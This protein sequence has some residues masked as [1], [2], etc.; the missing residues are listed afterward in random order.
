MN[1]YRTPAPRTKSPEDTP[2]LRRRL[3]CFLGAH[4]Y[5]SVWFVHEEKTVISF[6]GCP[7]CGKVKDIDVDTESI[8]MAL[9][10]IEWYRA[11][12]DP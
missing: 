7:H 2:S 12:E 10:F 8:P 3:F 6:L 1:P 9:E 11:K 4:A 5:E